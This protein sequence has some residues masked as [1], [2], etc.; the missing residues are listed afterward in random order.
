MK[1]KLALAAACLLGLSAPAQAHRPHGVGYYPLRPS[2]TVGFGFGFGYPYP[3]GYRYPVVYPPAWAYPAAV[4][5][6]VGVA[7]RPVYRT[8]PAPQTP[9]TVR[10][11]IYPAAG[12]SKEQTAD[13]R[14][15]CHVWAADR[16]GYDPT[17]GGGKASDAADYQRAFVAC[18]EG[19]HY[20]V[21]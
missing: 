7:P 17:L 16:S 9:S 2:V 12:Q 13:D 4:G 11:F 1:F 5:V 15:E 3:Y 21:K 6:H 10:L 8:Q 20:V 19:R 18:M 14:Y